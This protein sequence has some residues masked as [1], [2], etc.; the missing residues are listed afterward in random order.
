M[1]RDN[2]NYYYFAAEGGNLDYYFIYGPSIKKVEEGY[3]SLTGRVNL[4]QIWTLGY[5]QSRWS[6]GNEDRLMEVAE[7]FRSEKIS[8]YSRTRRIDFAEKLY[9]SKR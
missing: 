2:S 7:K 8:E 9:D 4:P 5:Q 6:Y 3:T 1:G